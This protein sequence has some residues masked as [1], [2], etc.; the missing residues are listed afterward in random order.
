MRTNKFINITVTVFI[1]VI[2]LWFTVPSFYTNNFINYNSNSLL[3]KTETKLTAQE[4]A[5]IESYN[6]P[7]YFNIFKFVNALIP[8]KK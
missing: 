2:A 3:P 6:K 7:V 4:P 8:G 1:L 5:D